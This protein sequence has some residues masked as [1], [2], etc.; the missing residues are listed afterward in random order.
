MEKDTLLDV[1]M[2]LGITVMTTEEAPTDTKEETPQP[3]P[4][5]KA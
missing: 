1:A 2:D 4:V 5:V 3:D